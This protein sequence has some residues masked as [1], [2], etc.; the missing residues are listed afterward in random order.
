MIKEF[1]SDPDAS[2]AANSLVNK[3][4]DLFD[5]FV[6]WGARLSVLCR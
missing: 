1:V 4:A 2:G 6:G 3:K 5:R